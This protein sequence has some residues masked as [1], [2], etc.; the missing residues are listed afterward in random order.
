MHGHA[1]AAEDRV[2]AQDVGV[3][4]NELAGAAEFA[5]SGGELLPGFAYMDFDKAAFE[6]DRAALGVRQRIEKLA[7]GP[8]GRCDRPAGVRAR[9]P[10]RAEIEQ[11]RGL[12]GAAPCGGWHGL[13]VDGVVHRFEREPREDGGLGGGEEGGGC[14]S[15]ANHSPARECISCLGL[16]Q[17]FAGAVRFRSVYVRDDGENLARRMG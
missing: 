1:C 6:R 16:S 11:A 17:R 13:L 10:S 12:T 15:H 14:R 7:S 9:A 3:S 2:A 4:D 8:R 5:Q